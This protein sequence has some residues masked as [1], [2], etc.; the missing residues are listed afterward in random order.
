MGHERCAHPCPECDL[1]LSQVTLAQILARAAALL[2]LA[3]ER[4]RAGADALYAGAT[5]Q[6]ALDMQTAADACLR[7]AAVLRA[8]T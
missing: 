8:R 7:A 4:E 5:T 1:E 2:A 3:S 6:D